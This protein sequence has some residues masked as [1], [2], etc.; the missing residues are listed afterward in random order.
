LPESFNAF[1]ERESRLSSIE[2]DFQ[3]QLVARED[4]R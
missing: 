4:L 1:I 3:S 2:R